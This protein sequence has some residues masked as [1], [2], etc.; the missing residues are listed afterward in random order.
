MLIHAGR[1]ACL[2]CLFG[3]EEAGNQPGAAMKFAVAPATPVVV[4]A[5]Q[6]NEVI[7][8]LVEKNEPDGADKSCPGRYIS[9]N[10][11]QARMQ[12]NQLPGKNPGC[13]M[14]GTQN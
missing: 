8:Y 1:G 2:E 13:G 3:P 6:A 14:C 4:G 9:I 5:M 7:R 10:L 11:W 12:S